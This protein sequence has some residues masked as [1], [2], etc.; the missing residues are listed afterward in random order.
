MPSLFF[1]KD[2]EITMAN[3]DI[4]LLFGVAGGG[5][6]S[7]ESGSLI[8][9][10]LNQIMSALNKSPL[11]VKV[12]LDTEAGG[13]KSWNTQLQSK[14]NAISTS[15]K[16][17]IQVS[18][19][20]IGT[21]AIADFKRQL[22]AVINTL[23]LDK[24][25]SITLTADGIGEVKS[26]L[27]E[28][29][30]AASEAARK[31]AEF[32]VQMEALNSLKTSVRQS[33]SSLTTGNETEE[34]KTRIAELNAQ[35]EQWAVKI[36]EVRASKTAATGE[37][38]AELEREGA[39]IQANILEIQ[40]ERQAVIENEAAKRA[41]TAANEAAA[42]S[43]RDSA[44]AIDNKNKAIK[45]GINL[46]TQMETAERNWTAAQS[47]STSGNYKNIQLNRAALEGY[48]AQLKNGGISLETFRSHL[49]SIGA[50]F[51]ADSNI[52][53]DAG[54]NVKTF[55]GH[56]GGLAS[57]FTSWLTVSQVIMQLYR[58]L[59]Q[60]VTAVKEVDTAMT[61]LKK[62]T[63]ETDAT[64]SRFLENATTRSKE[65][66]ATLAD[67][68]NATADFARLG[69]SLEDASQLADAALVYKNVGDGIEDISEASESL[70]STMKAFGVSAEDS[71]FIVDKFN[72][73]GNNFA[74]SSK[75][76]GDALLRSASALAAANNSLD[77]SIALITAANSTVQDADKVGTTL[78]TVS[79][80]L[81]AA[82]TE[83]EDAGE[84]TEGMANS[85]SEL[86]DELLALTGGKVDI[87]IDENTF[88]STYQIMKELS[89]VWGELT[90]ISRANILE[91]IGGKRNSN[92]VMSLLENFNVAEE[93]MES[94]ANA[95]GSAL[96]ENE[97]YL[98]SIEGKIS[99]FKATFQELGTTLIGSDFVKEVVELGTGILNILNALAKVIDTV[100][101]LNTVLLVTVGIIATIK[102]DAIKAFLVT[103][104]PNALTKLT[105]AVSKFFTGLLQLPSVL[106]AMNSQTAL[107]VPGT[108][109]LSVAFQTLGISASTAQIAVGALMAVLTAA[110]IIYQKVKQAEEERRQAAIDS[111]NA[112]AEESNEIVNLIYQYL[113]LNEAIK[114]D[115]S[116]SEELASTKDTLLSKLDTESERVKE[117][118]GEY[119][120]LTDKIKAAT[121]VSLQD[122][123]RDIR[124]GVNAREEALLD[125]GKADWG[126]DSISISGSKQDGLFSTSTETRKEQQLMYKALNALEKAG[127]ISSGS[128]S[129]YT[130]DNEQKYSQGFA[131]FAG[132]DENLDTIDGV[133][134]TYDQLGQMLDV[135]ADAAGSDNAVYEKLYDTYNSMTPAV[136]EYRES[137]SQL[138]SN[139]AEQYMLQGLIGK[140]M[141]TTQEEFE[142]YRNDVID[143]AVASG[144]FSGTHD[145][146]VAAIDS[147]M[148]SNAQLSEYMDELNRQEIL[149]EELQQKRRAIAESLVPKDYE[150]Y[151]EGTSAHFHALDNWLS[152][153]EDYKSKLSELSGDELAFVY[154][155][156]INQGVTSWDEITRQLENFNSETEVS[157]RHLESYKDTIK[158][159]WNSEDFEGTKDE[160]TALANTV[161]GISP[162]KITE[163]AEER[164]LLAAILDEDGMNAQFL[165]KVLEQMA[166]GNDGL[167]LITEDALKLNEALDG[168]VD[169]F[170]SVT[171]AKSRY[172]AA[173]S[174]EEKDTDF[175]SY[176]EAFEVL[177]EQ[178]EAGTTNSNA[179][180]AAAQFLFG[181]EQLAIWGWSDGLDQIYEAMEK[182]KQVFSD[183]DSAGAGFIQ[184]LYEMSEAGEMVDENGEKLLEISRD[185]TGAYDFDIDPDNLDKIAEK[186][187]MTREAVLAC[188]E[189]LSM[190]GDVDFYD[191]TEVMGVIEDIG[192]A[193]ETAGGKAV[194]VE[195]LT[196]QLM[197]LGKTDKEIYDILSALSQLDGVVLLDVSSDVDTLTGSLTNLGLATSD[198]ITISVDYEGLSELMSQLGYTKEDA[199]NT[200]QKLGEL[201]NI[202]LVNAQGEVGD[203]Q[204]ALDYISTLE[205]T[206][207][208][209][210]L[211]GVEGAVEDV[212][213]A[214]TDDV[215]SEINDISSAADTTT[216]KV[217]KIGDA[218]DNVNGKECTVYYNV[219]RKNTILDAVGNLLG[220]ARGTD[221]AP[222]TDA[223]VGEEAPEL[224]QS[225]ERAYLV[226]VSGPEVVHLNKGDRVYTA[227]ETRKILSSGKKIIGS[228]PSYE[229]GRATTSGLRVETNKTG[230]SGKPYK[231]NVE[232][233]VDTK[234][235]ATVDDSALEEQLE[236]TLDK[237]KEEID[238]IIGNFEHSIF[239]LE[240]NGGSTSEIVAIYR[241]MQEAVHAQAEKYRALGLDE[242][243]DYI[244]ELQK[245][246]WEY[247]DSIHETIVAE[248]EKMVGERENA[249]KLTENWMN[250][251]IEA[252]NI[253]G[254]EIN[255]NDIVSYYKQMQDIIHEQAEYYRSQGYSDTSDEV[256]E[257]SDLWWEYADSIKQVKQQVVDSLIDMVEAA[258]SAVDEVQNA[259][260]VL[261][262]A[263][264]EY[265]A[266]G[267]I[268]VDSLQAII[269]LGP[270]YMQLLTDE[271][272]QLVI[273]EER[274]NAVIAARTQQLALESAMTYI[275]RIRLAL[276][277]DSAESLNNLLYVTTD[278][279]DATWGLVYAELALM[280]QMGDLDDAQYNAALHNIQSLQSLANSAISSIGRVAGSSAEELENMKTGLDD[281]LKY[282]MDML[283][284][285][286]NDQIEALED[287]KDA[288]EDIIELRKEALEA[289]QE[290]AD[291][292]DEVA[293]KVKEIAKLQE[294]INALSLDDSRDAQAQ[295]AQLEEEMYELQ[296][297]LADKQ[298]DYAVNAQQDALDDMS[299]AYAAEKDEEISVLENSISS[300]EKLYRMAMDYLENDIGTDYERLKNELCQWNYE[301]G[302][303][304]ESELVSAWEA[305]TAA[306]QRYGSYVSALNSIDAD[307]SA[308]SGS[309]HNDIVTNS[310]YDTTSTKEDNIHAII[311]EMYANSRAHHSADADGK[312]YLNKRNLTLGAMLA[313]YGI[314]A[315]RGNDGVWYVNK[316]GGELLYEK[317]KKYT[318]HTGG[319]AGDE[320]TLKQNEVMAV[321]EKGE[322]VLDK[323]K[324]RGLY[325][326]IDFATTL[327]DKFGKL[328]SS[329]GYNTVFGGA[330]NG[331]PK[332]AELAPITESQSSSVEFGDVYI[333]GANDET[334][335]KHREIN[336][337]FT[338]RVLEQLKIKR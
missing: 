297:E 30:D 215:V 88:K 21:G 104:L 288:Y 147:A 110:V 335:E 86:R 313:Q 299:E 195:R 5:S 283:K 252:G 13:Q 326:L 217:Y 298:S 73:T 93:V 55:S 145:D 155:L 48:I 265:A 111:A 330:E 333:Y 227:S 272:G 191:L 35:Y 186:M 234:V 210:N 71:M 170:D 197:T 75:G 151:E 25:T 199:E 44:T 190:W 60:M 41:E 316:V 337:E 242:N 141:P 208:E 318:Y 123:E 214:S 184:R 331:M 323:Q 230:T 28:A 243:S 282:V 205:F 168:M 54:K 222:E 251:A 115:A 107:A 91:M 327:A 138:N 300:T 328:V 59:R 7:G 303:S 94:T 65:L 325:R 306:A 198:G 46:L 146:I 114:T 332:S 281:I 117:L 68:V 319:I 1:V 260:D 43:E 220:F 285:K 274:I 276:Q 275:E 334:V 74:I 124:G 167:A 207:T 162:D 148:A 174:V 63:D 89:E 226:G 143:N 241:K 250:N 179:F 240:E 133:L 229:G 47:G 258:S 180:W 80:F 200:I 185:A 4:S 160:L 317:Y 233:N 149:A 153:V 18:N 100:G 262:E 152:Q 112:A 85:V 84:S 273:N 2:G 31:T 14:L 192:I 169:M 127:F 224:V 245:Q 163:L 76:V 193:A 101:G 53:K 142:Q 8:Q 329:S 238:D 216:T 280:H 293:E 291:Y 62:V 338:N 305:A 102:A 266:D 37:Y 171:E 268:S 228:I 61:E 254:T 284:Q 173:M 17:S 178:F 232:A 225:G 223:L 52:I 188:L 139:L 128:Y 116:V 12:G 264:N 19:I 321:L 79:M 236:D 239:L 209:E 292:Q 26:Q 108:S 202:S 204:S 247:Q 187:G 131:F 203:V 277:D 113:N 99:Q 32:K 307:I 42:Q 9:S 286:I 103:T 166:R 231:V 189:A 137:I 310:T 290:E 96:A 194:N 83:A 156:T 72:E 6:L 87:Q 196:E 64:Y 176:A 95:A 219:K 92:V 130:D 218:L 182:N 287:M 140:E 126:T 45:Q 206:T 15:G 51:A 22:N 253:Q 70:I 58:A 270:Q 255:A 106:K 302:N 16:F 289:A 81:R 105:G 82:K 172:D 38:R 312:A 181:S 267:Y 235:K 49:A 278:A 78:K 121:I 244:Q 69:Y 132:L 246:W 136:D 271:N 249:I 66:G 324:E 120:N 308:A 56:M 263:A 135:V 256:S 20:K 221:D 154:D 309:T 294:R 36:E 320:P 161:D 57:K 279:T 311:K 23:N 322:A 259:Y 315:V 134:N 11:K 165:A 158:T 296:N 159:L 97:K 150:N 3:A 118:A 29:G 122:S 40:Q 269:D 33:L 212:N 98:D 24:G 175:K 213:D 39:A 336:R 144:E 257:L 211:H 34:E 157:R 177:N 67:T 237:L 50:E 125:A 119:A 77:E 261:H 164:D 304:L 314:T 183:A 129:S 248:Y 27:K 201:D 109:K 301:V 90:D 295:K 10:Q